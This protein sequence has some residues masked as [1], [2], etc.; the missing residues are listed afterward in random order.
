MRGLQRNVGR[1]RNQR[2][3]MAQSFGLWKGMGEA[4]LIKL[5]IG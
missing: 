2:K 5:R 4:S 1:R 3:S